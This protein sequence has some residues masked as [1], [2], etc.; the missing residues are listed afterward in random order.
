MDTARWITATIGLITAGLIIFLVRRDHLHTRY[1]VWWLPVAFVIGILGVFPRLVDWL[2]PIIGIRYPPIIPLLAG[3]IALI[4][5][6]LVMDIERSR[7]EIKLNRLI[8]RIGIL[9]GELHK[10]AGSKPSTSEVE[11]LAE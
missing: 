6:I 10:G 2:A 1:A 9:E 3:L 7:N 8:Q 11:E 4:V 5:K